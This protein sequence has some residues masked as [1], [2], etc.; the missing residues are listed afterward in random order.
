MIFQIAPSLTFYHIMKKF[1]ILL[2]KVVIKFII[3]GTIWK[4]ETFYSLF[5]EMGQSKKEIRSFNFGQW[6]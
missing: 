3:I 5:L 4:R 2:N 1:N 6:E